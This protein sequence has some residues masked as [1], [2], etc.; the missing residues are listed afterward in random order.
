MKN[1]FKISAIIFGALVLLYS[2]SC[3]TEEDVLPAP[4]FTFST[5]PSGTEFSEGD[6]LTFTI[7]F[8]AENGL[9]SFIVTPTING[10][11]GSPIINNP[12][13]DL[14]LEDLN[15]GSFDYSLILSSGFS[16][17]DSVSVA[18]ELLDQSELSATDNFEFTI[19]SLTTFTAVLL[20][21]PLQDASSAT[22]FSS[23][24]G[25]TVTEAEVNAA[26]APNSS[27]I[28]FGYYYGGSDMAS[29]A[30]PANYP[31]LGGSIDISDW[32]TQ[33]ATTFRSTTLSAEDFIGITSG[34]AVEAAFDAGTDEGGVITNL[35]VGDV[36]AF[37]LDVAKGGTKGLLR[38]ISITGT[39]NQNDNMEVEIY[40]A[41]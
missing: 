8:T 30:A 18:L 16:G 17:G 3:D 19:S 38:V 7:N 32:T 5:S 10:V 14:G 22:W 35:S 31:T 25:R 9:S 26:E 39:F 34:A 37:E 28:D 21:A 4:T 36:V 29:L 12:Q 33:N 15:S 24:L 20:F 6:T 41:D 1:L 23:N 27:D 2:T 13:V 40:L 11:E